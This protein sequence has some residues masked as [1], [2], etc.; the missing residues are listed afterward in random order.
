[1]ATADARAH[2]VERLR[3]AD[4]NPRASAGQLERLPDGHPSSPR[5][6]GESLPA[7]KVR[8]L[9]DSEHAEHVADVKTR[10]STARAARLATDFRHTIDPRQEIWSAE[11]RTIHDQIVRER[12]AAA[13]QVPSERWAI[14]AG[15]L[16]GAGKT[17]VLR[18]YAGIEQARY[19][20]INPDLIKADLATRGL[21]PLVNGLTPMEAAEL[22]HEESSHLAKRLARMAQADGRNVI[23]DIT[24][25]EADSASRR[26]ESL[27]SGGYT[28]V[29]GLFVA[30]GVEICIERADAR[31]RQGH[32]AYR[33]GSGLGGRFV[34]EEMIRVQADATWGSRNRANFELLKQRFD[35]WS[36]YDNSGRMPVLDAQHGP[37][38]ATV[39]RFAQ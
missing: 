2:A 17:T 20:V 10:L 33:A 24:L 29:T 30:A 37:V 3:L 12:Y 9:T 19:L 13:R 27:R 35:A 11:R 21:I 1:M 7:D 26:V 4:T 14:V 28:L 36:V 18:D 34:A 6:A 8:P 38:R 23:W 25:S 32:D 5:Y 15:G 31:Y 39:Q 16:P 22:V